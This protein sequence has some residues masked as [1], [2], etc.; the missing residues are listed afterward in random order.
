MSTDIVL[1]TPEYHAKKSP[2]GSDG[3]MKCSGWYSDSVGSSFA[4][5]GT[6]AHH[7]SAAALIEIHSGDYYRGQVGPK[8]NVCDDTMIE[9]VDDY[10][11]LVR[12]YAEGGELHVEVAVPIEHLT[13]EA[14]ATGT[15]DGVII[16]RYNHIEDGVIRVGQEI[17]VIDLKTG[18]GV[19]VSAERNSQ[20]MMYALG[21][22][23]LFSLIYG[24]FDRVRLVISQP[25]IN[26]DSEWIV[27]IDELMAF[28]E[29]IKIVPVGLNPS[30]KACRW[31]A[32][33]SKCPAIQ[34]Q[35]MDAFEVVPS[36]DVEAVRL[37]QLMDQVPQIENWCKAIRGEVELRIL[38]GEAVPGRK[39]VQGKR[40]NRAWTDEASVIEKLKSYRFKNEQIYD[41]KLLSPTKIE[42]LFDETP[43]KWAVL[44]HLI[45][46]SEGKPSVALESDKRPKL[47]KVDV[48]GDFDEVEVSDA[49]DDFF[50]ITEMAEPSV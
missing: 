21:A 24:D 37:G 47:I 7:F 28:G 13:G 2:S 25:R 6:D 36:P 45:S 33:K 29:T 40:G 8:G 38:N 42:K 44:S 49:A 20:L 27:S 16:N 26:N 35:V 46:Q 9:C 32:A 11:G 22:I 50:A 23:E 4:D 18:M 43:K 15:S 14:G 41:Q 34:Q 19:P 17:I 48:M 10:I 3:W 30:E 1:T 12:K 5:W 39:L 31:C